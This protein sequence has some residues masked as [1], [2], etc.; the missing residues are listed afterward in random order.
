VASSLSAGS[1]LPSATG[2]C[3]VWREGKRWS[4]RGRAWVHGV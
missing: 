3:C 4:G 1:S 2:G